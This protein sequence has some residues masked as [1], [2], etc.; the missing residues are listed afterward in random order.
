MLDDEILSRVFTWDDA[1]ALEGE[2]L[3]LSGGAPGAVPLRVLVARAKLLRGEAHMV[4][5][6]LF[7]RG[8]PQPLL[9]QDTYLARHARLGDYA[10]F[11]TPVASDAQGVEYEACF[12]HAP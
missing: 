7:M 5:F 10:F 3:E 1:R 9:A 8:P 6:S 2:S 11:V 4:Q 12:S